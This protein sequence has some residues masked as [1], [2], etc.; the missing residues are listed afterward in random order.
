MAKKNN[1]TWFDVNEA[2]RKGIETGIILCVTTL[3]DK[4]GF[5]Q[6][7]TIELIEGVAKLVVSMSEGRVTLSDLK[8]VQLDE[9]LMRFQ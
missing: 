1:P 8:K 7:K 4:M 2:K 5:D 9:Y 6:D 3:T